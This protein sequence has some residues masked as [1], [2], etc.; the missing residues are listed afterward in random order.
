MS[1]LPDPSDN[2]GGGSRNDDS[3]TPSSKDDQIARLTEENRTLRLD[4]K[5]MT[6]A[7]EIDREMV[8]SLI[9]AQ[10][11]LTEKE[12]LDSAKDAETLTDFL[13]KLETTTDAQR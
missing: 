10:F 1:S 12:L 5:N 9:L 13:A 8:K 11:P 4:L 3:A 7:R 6:E 2:H